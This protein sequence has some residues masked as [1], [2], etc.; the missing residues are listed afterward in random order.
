MKFCVNILYIE[1]DRAY[2]PILSRNTNFY[3]QRKKRII[4]SIFYCRMIIRIFEIG[5]V[6]IYHFTLYLLSSRLFNVSNYNA[7]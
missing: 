4:L 3:L 1:I 6:Q 7:K 2:L 5:G